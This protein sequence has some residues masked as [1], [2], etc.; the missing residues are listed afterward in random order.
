MKENIETLKIAGL[1]EEQARIYDFLLGKNPLS[2]SSIGRQVGIE[3]S[4]TYKVLGQLESL[5]LVSRNK[6][7]GETTLY[8]ALHPE[9]IGEIAKNKKEE[10]ERSF[11][12]VKNDLGKIISDHNLSVGR[13]GIRFFEGAEGLKEINNGILKSSEDIY[14]IRSNIDKTEPE[15]K[16]L[17]E[18]QIRKKVKSGKKTYIIGPLP[19]EKGKFSNPE[20]LIVEDKE[21][22]VERRVIEDLLLPTQILMYGHD[23][24]SITDHKNKVT[25]IIENDSIRETFD[26][27]FQV[28]WDSSKK[29]EEL[30]L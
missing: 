5:E 7:K 3:R 23:K 11:E 10:A 24:V 2:A 21:K 1:S 4:L 6:E 15:S 19:G 28:L 18:D 26:K 29:V 20:K 13:P 16:E 14:L 12:K 17:I 25:T 27:I 8:K 22:L 30:G 9:R